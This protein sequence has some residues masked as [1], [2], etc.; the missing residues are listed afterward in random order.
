MALVVGD[1]LG[2][3]QQLAGIGELDGV[4]PIPA[5]APPRGNRFLNGHAALPFG[6]GQTNRLFLDFK[7]GQTGP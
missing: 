1:A 7:H 3:P 6:R 5:P 2:R 4:A